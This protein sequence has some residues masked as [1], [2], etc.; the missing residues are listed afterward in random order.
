MGLAGL[1]EKTMY[2]SIMYPLSSINEDFF[3]CRELGYHRKAVSPSF[4]TDFKND[5]L[6]YNKEDVI[7]SYDYISANKEALP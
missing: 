2:D 1:H 7:R 3:Y 6:Y 5:W 4:Y